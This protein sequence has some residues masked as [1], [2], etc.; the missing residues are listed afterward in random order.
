MNL[1]ASKMQSNRLRHL[2]AVTFLSAGMFLGINTVDAKAYDNS[3]SMKD[4][5]PAADVLK[6]K[7]GVELVAL[8]VTAAEHMLDFRYKVIDGDK[9]ATLFKRDNKPFLVHQPSG[10]VLTVQNT[11]KVGPLRN[12]GKP[13]EGRTYWMFFRNYH[14]LVNKGDKVSVKI[15]DF[16]VENIIVE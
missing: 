12:S 1:R 3:A 8:R 7:W 9:S 5:A 15:G 13:K 10:K 2:L 11:A 16:L 14:G 6:E 4:I